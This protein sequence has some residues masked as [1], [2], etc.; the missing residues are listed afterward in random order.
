M[1]EVK[2][3]ERFRVPKSAWMCALIVSLCCGLGVCPSNLSGGPG[4]PPNPL[5]LPVSSQS[6][7]HAAGEKAALG[8]AEGDTAL[9]FE[10]VTFAAGL[11]E[12]LDCMMGHSAAF[13]D[14][15]GDGSPDL[16]FG[17]FADRPPEQYLCPEGP[18]PNR[19]FRNSGDGSF[20]LNSQADVERYG[21]CSGS[22]FVNLDEDEDLD[23]V[24]THNS[25]SSG[26][27]I[28]TLSNLV[29]RNDEGVFTDV[30]EGSN[31][32][33]TGMRARNV[34]PLDYDGDTR[35]DLFIVA[36]R[37]GNGP[38]SRLFRNLGDF[39]FE[40]QTAAAGL[41]DMY[42]LGAAAADVNLDGWPDLFLSYV[43]HLSVNFNRLFVNNADG[44]FRHV[45]PLDTV[46]AWSRSS[47]EDWTAGV[48]FGDVNRDG[49]LDLVIAHH[50]ASAWFS[51]VPVRL[52]MNRGI[53]TGEVVFEDVTEAAELPGIGAKAPHAEIQDMDNDGWPDIYISVHVEQEGAVVPLVLR[54]DGGGG[55]TPHFSTPLFV[56]ADE[57]MRDR[58]YGA[59]G[60]T[61][62]FDR[63]GRLDV[64]ITE[65]WPDRDS[66]LYR[67]TS[68]SGN[69]L[70]VI[71][72]PTD[73]AN[74]MGIGARVE[75]FEAGRLGE[76]EALIGRC[77]I[78]S[79][80]GYSSGQEAVAHFG[81]ADRELVDVRVVLPHGGATLDREGIADGQRLVVRE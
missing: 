76:A 4:G 16:F 12:P 19:V 67:N 17:T 62:D 11:T 7:L 69:Y 56:V 28:K 44:T 29:F 54:N 27:P 68:A 33:V 37:F 18:R 59:S 9:A 65:W 52:Y 66:V 79:G 53:S 49:W 63:D 15:D 2:R 74:R 61:G 6:L 3:G 42:G 8:H 75:V 55:P 71:V 51:P 77:E 14:A 24:V 23:L 13:G 58:G 57:G 70:E 60:P 20:V 64:F 78:M 72:R 46:F 30:T 41:P 40:D 34:I 45:E 81:L 80:F 43:E 39:R 48:A 35:I 31:L 1:S 32:T 25:Q 73:G 26:G 21:R 50:Y 47:S 36:D 10:N 38:R 22:V 5:A